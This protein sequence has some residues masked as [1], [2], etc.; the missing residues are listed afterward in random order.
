MTMRY[1]RHPSVRVTA[2]DQEGVALHLETHRYFT[3]NG[4]GFALLDALDEP[5]TIP[6]LGERLTAAYDVTVPEAERAARAF[7]AQC[8]DRGVVVA[9][10]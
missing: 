8:L 1:R 6:E 7:V 9:A 3:L 10:D 5:R 4:T 2:L